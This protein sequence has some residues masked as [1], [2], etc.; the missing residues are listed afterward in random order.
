MVW[1][2][3]SH[4]KTI[5]QGKKMEHINQELCPVVLYMAT[6]SS[7]QSIQSVR[8][9]LNR[10]AKFHQSTWREFDWITLSYSDVVTDLRKILASGSSYST[11]NQTLAFLKGVLRQAWLSGQYSADEYHKIHAIRKF[12]GFRLPT[13]Q[14]LQKGQIN[15]LFES[16]ANDNNRTR[17]LRDAAVLSLGFHLALRRSEIG[18]V[19]VSDIDLDRM[20][21]KVI[22]KGNKQAELPVPAIC[23]AHLSNWIEERNIQIKDGAIDGEFLLGRVHSPGG[24]IASFDGLRGEAIAVILKQV[25]DRSSLLLI[26]KLTPHDMRRT[27]IT[28]WLHA[29]NA[30]IAQKLARHADIQ[31]TLIYDRGDAWSEMCAL[32]EVC[33]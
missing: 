13:G 24:S 31:T 21:L 1:R 28:E 7:P 12:K 8:S 15:K 4:F 30:R 6:L 22:G 17:G 3:L 33:G 20:T 32:Q 16:C 25:V 19:K 10:I 18:K 2:H 14:A 27:R 23:S 11:A 9:R 5:N 29:G 26:K